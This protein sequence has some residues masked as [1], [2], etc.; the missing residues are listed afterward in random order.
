MTTSSKPT[1]PRRLVHDP[2]GHNTAVWPMCPGEMITPVPAF[3]TRSHGPTPAVD[4]STWRL[5][6]DGLVERPATFSLA[7][8]AE[9]FPRR[10]VTATLMCAGLRRDEFLAVGPLPGELPWGPEPVSTGRWRG[11]PLADLLRRVGVAPGASHV[12]FIGLDSVERLGQ[13]F[14]FGGS[15]ELE[16]AMGDEVLLATELNGRPLPPAHGFPLRMV[17]PGW[18]GA[19]SVK[20]LGRI[21]VAPEPSQNYFQARAYRMLASTNPKEPRDIRE[22]TALTEVPLN[23][24]ILDPVAGAVLP[25]GHV[26]VRGWTMGPGMRHVAA[27][28][29]SVT[30]GRRWVRADITEPTTGWTWGL[31]EATVELAPGDH[32]IMVR[33]TDQEG[34]TQPPV[35]GDTWN[36]KGYNNNAWHRVAVRAE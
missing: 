18:I 1:E 30:G 28:D 5:E 35:P 10:E 34:N 3:F 14:G 29:V 20:W 15:I 33:A 16:K 32:V 2:E 25:A 21:R 24:V 13:C 23:A 11:F 12:E 7:E 8:L 17:V 27:V 4:P 36:V 31:W 22:G 19:R 9:V 6:V 26:R